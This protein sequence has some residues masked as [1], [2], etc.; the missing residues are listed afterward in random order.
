MEATSR[1]EIEEKKKEKKE[2]GNVEGKEKE[3]SADKGV[4]TWE[5]WD[6]PTMAWI[7]F[8]RVDGKKDKVLCRGLSGKDLDEIQVACKVPAPPRKPVLDEKGQRKVI[9]GVLQTEPDLEDEN[10]K[11]E[12]DLADRKRMVM[13]LERGLVDPDGSKVPGSNYEEKYEFLNKRVRG[14]IIKLVNFINIHLSNLKPTD[15]DFFG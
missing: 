5:K 7:E 2:V 12:T 6:Q 3:V 10:Y 11:K 15:L 8:E 4:L 13:I 9:R 1:T 14:D